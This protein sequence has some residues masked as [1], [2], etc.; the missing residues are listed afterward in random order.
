[1]KRR[2]F[3]QKSGSLVSSLPFL[4]IAVANNLFGKEIAF[5]DYKALI[6]LQ[7]DG[8]NDTFNTFVP[9]QEEAY[10]NYEKA[11]KKIA[12]AN[13]DLLEDENYRV[14]ENGYYAPVSKDKNAYAVATKNIEKSYKKGI[15]KVSDSLGFNAMMPELA[16]LYKK[17]VLSVVENVGVLVEPTTQN[18]IVNKNVT[19]PLFLFA[20][21]H[22]R[23]AVETAKPQEKISK[24]WLGRVADSWS[25]I[26]A[27]I[28]LNISFA[29]MN[30]MLVGT[31][32]API[33]FGNSP[34]I[35]NKYNPSDTTIIS[36]LE[37]FSQLQNDNIFYSLYNKMNKKAVDFSNTFKEAWK[38]VPDFSSFDLKNSYGDTLFSVPTTVDINMED[39]HA[40]SSSIFR[41]LQTTAQMIKIGKDIFHYKREV[42]YISLGGFD[43]HSSQPKDHSKKLRSLSLALSDFYKALEEM[44]LEKDVVLAT[45]SDFGRTLLSNGDGTDHG[46]GGGAFLLSG[47]E[48]FNG[49][50]ILGYKIT[51]Y[52]LDSETFYQEHR[53]KGRLIPTTSIEQMYAPILDWFGVD[54]KTMKSAFP[55][56]VNFRKDVNNYKSAFLEEV[57]L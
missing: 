22:Q 27:P 43:F 34:D 6:V 25:P 24:G 48:N 4:S 11:R 45:T 12:I 28:G 46:W 53:Q 19:L 26:N 54:E 32:T 40:L 30:R 42:F 21:D 55:N 38:N 18:D 57:F 14:N 3:L 51:N 37:R 13:E 44:G 49:G 8:G 5:S 36:L 20:H 47:A 52:S 23:R 41:D 29:G 15:Y 31:K 33:T 7:L 2:E 17:G 9:F 35:Y 1:M 10:K 16:A 56:L 50:K 39:L